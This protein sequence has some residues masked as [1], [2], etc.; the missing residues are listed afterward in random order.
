MIIDENMLCRSHAHRF[1]ER[2][3]RGLGIRHSE[4]KHLELSSGWRAITV[5]PIAN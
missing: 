2:R 4:D 3:P 5:R 1:I